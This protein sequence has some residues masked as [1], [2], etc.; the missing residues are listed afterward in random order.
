[1]CAN[2]DGCLEDWLEEDPASWLFGWLIMP[3]I[4]NKEGAAG[5]PHSCCLWTIPLTCFHPG[6]SNQPHPIGSLISSTNIN[7]QSSSLQ[8]PHSSPFSSLPPKIVSPPVKPT[9]AVLPVMWTYSRPHRRLYPWNLSIL[10]CVAGSYACR[11]PLDRPLK[12]GAGGGGMCGVGG[13]GIHA[14]SQFP[15]V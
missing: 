4:R 6:L 3:A 12:A 9:T 5:V 13:M 8:H 11:P 15:W 1:M 7:P 10:W 14:S 2:S